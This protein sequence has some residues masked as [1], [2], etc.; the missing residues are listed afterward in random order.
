MAS[1]KEIRN[2]IT[3][4]DE[5]VLRHSLV[6]VQERIKGEIE[7]GRATETRTAAIFAGLA[8]S[9]GLAVPLTEAFELPQGETHSFLLLVFIVFFLCLVTGSYYAL[10][11]LGVT[12][13][14][15]LIPETVYDFHCSGSKDV[16]REHIAGIIWECEQTVQSNSKKLYWLNLLQ[17]N[18]MGVVLCFSLAAL[19]VLFENTVISQFYIVK[20]VLYVLTIAIF[21]VWLFAKKLIERFGI[22]NYKKQKLRR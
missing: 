1:I 4:N 20:Y 7:R 11:I 22:W 14:Y 9:A 17:L 16:L 13:Q 5:A 2:K 15:R 19:S 12:K 21:I 6:F 10:R 8:V 3:S 18:G